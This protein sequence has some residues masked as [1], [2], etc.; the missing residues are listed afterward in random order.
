MLFVSDDER[1]FERKQSRLSIKATSTLGWARWIAARETMRVWFPWCVCRA[2]SQRPKRIG[3][4][5]RSRIPR[6]LGRLTP[7]TSAPASPRSARQR[8]DWL[9]DSIMRSTHAPRPRSTH[10]G[11]REAAGFVYHRKD[12]PRDAG[13]DQEGGEEVSRVLCGA[14]QAPAGWTTVDLTYVPPPLRHR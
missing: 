11:K 6:C 7:S 13:F 4:G 9:A 3:S 10:R 5:Y 1:A 8:T 12:A 2:P 14:T